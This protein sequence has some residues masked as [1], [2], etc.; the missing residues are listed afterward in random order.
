MKEQEEV[1]LT[2]FLNLGFSIF[3]VIGGILTH[4]VAIVSGAIHDFSDSL[5]IGLSLVLEKKKEKKKI[6]LMQTFFS[7]TIFIV[8]A[9]LALGASFYRIVKPL[10][11]NIVGMLLFSL[12]G[13]A[14][15][16]YATYKTSKSMNELEKS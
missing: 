13:I 1:K 6:Q 2:F 8:G 7:N 11:I 9:T 14:I 12:F 4:S 5:V 10:S 16:G 15:N 3:G